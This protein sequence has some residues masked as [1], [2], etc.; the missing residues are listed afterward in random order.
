MM[1]LWRQMLQFTRMRGM[2]IVS[3]GT[4]PSEHALSA[5]MNCST[6]NS[7]SRNTF[8]AVWIG[9]PARS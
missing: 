4:S 8:L 6:A 5:S 3:A 1:P 9:A 7:R 2:P